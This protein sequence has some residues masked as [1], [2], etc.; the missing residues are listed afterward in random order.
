M[1]SILLLADNL[2]KDYP[3]FSFT[4]GGE[5]RWAPDNQS[6]FY[7]QASS[8]TAALLHELSHAI[9][10]HT[11]YHRDVELLELERA[12][13]RFAAGHLAKKYKVVIS[14]DQIED[15]LDSYRDWLHARSTCPNCK[16]IGL[17]T[18]PDQYKCIACFEV[19]RVND[20]RACALRR[21]KVKTK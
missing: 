19:W 11:D 12:A 17:Q 8:D 3:Q 14:N 5:F 18:K 2:Q 7:D 21:Y 15:S 6:I 4:A 9:L 1:Q 10:A 13:W 20:A 16:A